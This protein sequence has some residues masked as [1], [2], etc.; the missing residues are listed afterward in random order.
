MIGIKDLYNHYIRKPIP[1][2]CGIIC[3][4]ID[5]AMAKL[6]RLLNDTLSYFSYTLVLNG[7]ALVDY[8][9][10]HLSLRPYDL[11]ITTP[12][13]KVVTLEVTDDFSAWCLMADEMTTYEITDTRYAV[14]STFSP[15][16]IHSQNK[17]Q[18]TETE[19]EGI[20]KW[21]NELIRYGAMENPL[22]KLCLTS[23]YSLFICELVN[24][25]TT[26]NSE[27]NQYG[28]PSELFLKFLKLLPQNYIRHHDIQFYADRL[29]VTTIYLSRVV[30]KHS[31]QTVK[32]HIDRLL[33]SEASV[34]L[35]RTDKP[36]ATIAENLNFATPQ[37]F[38][39][40]FYRN[41]GVSPRK[42]RA[43]Q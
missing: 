15:L 20:R 32:E 4:P 16:L 10:I 13:A 41:K 36:I 7:K 17:L 27:M 25:I 14:L 22:T 26:G 12:G 38:C 9:G 43:I 39:K 6:N 42:Y 29:S 37:S 3:E 18:L 33:L 28:P 8:N 23:L 24:I 1:E 34:Q 2:N 35:K 31:G 11:M 30:K 40:F 5:V 19:F 21:M